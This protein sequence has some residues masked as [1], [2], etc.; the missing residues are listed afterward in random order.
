VLA[1]KVAMAFDSA[2]VVGFEAVATSNV[3]LRWEVTALRN[4]AH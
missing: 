2:E 1:V 4:I 3:S